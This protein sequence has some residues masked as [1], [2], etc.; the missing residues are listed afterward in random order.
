MSETNPYTRKCGCLHRGPGHEWERCDRHE[1]EDRV[2]EQLVETFGKPVCPEG[3]GDVRRPK[4]M[5]EASDC[6]RHEVKHAWDKLKRAAIAYAVD[7]EE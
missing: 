2:E 4:C 7:D 1:A 3:C 5:W 6:P